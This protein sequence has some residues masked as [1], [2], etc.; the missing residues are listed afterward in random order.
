MTTSFW[1]DAANSLPPEIRHRYA[2]DF[3][4][5]ERIEQALDLAIETWVSV[6]RVLGRCFERL[7]AGLRKTAKMLDAAARRLSPT[8]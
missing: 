8:H 2:A 7:A 4:A 3:E 1:R 5:A 6:R